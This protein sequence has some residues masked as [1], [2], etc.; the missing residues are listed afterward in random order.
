MKKYFI[1]TFGCAM[2][3]SDSERIEA[4]L[5]R[6][7]WK[8]SPSPES[9]DLIVVNMCSIRQS[10]VNRVFGRMKFFSKLKKKNPK[11][12]TMLTGCILK[13][14]FEKLRAGFDFIL[15]VSRIASFSKIAKKGE[16]THIFLKRTE[17]EGIKYLK[18]GKTATSYIPVSVGCDN[19]CTYCVV[20]Y[21]RGKETC[22]APEEI[23]KEAKESIRQGTKEIWLLG[24]NVNAY[25]HP[26]LKKKTVD[27][28]DLLRK[29]ER[30]PGYFW[31][32]FISSNPKYFSEKL[33]STISDS[34]KITKYLSLPLQSGDEGILKRMNRGYTAR[35]YEKTVEKILE[36]IPECF[37]STDAIVG[38]PGETEKQ[39]QNTAKLFE[40]LKFDMA[41]I[42]Q[43]SPRRGTEAFK[44]K[45][46][47]PREEKIRREMILNDIL[48]KTAF[49]KNEKLVGKT[50][51][52]LPQ[53]FKN[54]ILEGKTK[55]YKT[56]KFEGPASLIGKFAKVEVTECL[57]WG[58]KGKEKGVK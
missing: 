26:D 23:I 50:V 10:A 44:M 6:N 34:E 24:E 18:Q 5:Q 12:K 4:H 31:I 45:D 2:N 29:I 58:L 14:D 41:Y 48:K 51:E 28:A 36:K 54:G 3:V 19:F 16:R 7:G 49:E 20:P 40:K 25:N 17:K 39:F 9:S 8:K 11:L 42:S 47:V 30:I 55:E 38:F 32:R 43:Y 15:P 46:N 1:I 37:L 35:E 22:R 33:I 53:F 52:A 56:I 57:P 27:F 21:T 13:R